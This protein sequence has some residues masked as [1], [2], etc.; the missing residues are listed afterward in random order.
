MFEIFA[1][2]QSI[3]SPFL[4]LDLP[5]GKLPHELALTKDLILNDSCPLR[6]ST[7]CTPFLFIS[8]LHFINLVK[9]FFFMKLFFKTAFI[10]FLH[11]HVKN[12]TNMDK[13]KI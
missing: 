12:Y 2:K 8:N 3:I 10:G 4:N 7:S 11:L 1:G 9:S 5:D 13:Q 6:T